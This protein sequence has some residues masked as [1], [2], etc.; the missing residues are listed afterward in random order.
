[1]IKAAFLAVFAVASP[2]LAGG[3]GELRAAPAV[4]ARAADDASAADLLGTMLTGADG[5]DLGTVCDLLVDAGQR[6]VAFIGVR[7]AAS[8]D[9]VVAVP[10]TPLA[11]AAAGKGDYVASQPGSISSDLPFAQQAA[12]DPAFLDVRR[13]LLGRPVLAAAGE[14]IGRLV[15][16]DVDL[17]S[18]AIGYL[19]ITTTEMAGRGSGR[20]AIPWGAIADLDSERAIVLGL[21]AGDILTSPRD[22]IAADPARG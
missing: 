16:F 2:L 6:R 13:D 5:R 7:A 14:S 4:P 12:A 17:R 9:G 11:R 19:F 18:G 10:W 21:D 22:S 15:D 1:M 8:G 20:R 3:C